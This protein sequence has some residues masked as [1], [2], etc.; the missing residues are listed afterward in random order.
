MS[1]IEHNRVQMGIHI[2]CIQIGIIFR[3][4]VQASIVSRYANS[5]SVTA[6]CCDMIDSVNKDNEGVIIVVFG[7]IDTIRVVSGSGDCG[8][9]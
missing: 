5:R 9:V 8:I 1:A 6:G 7:E 3:I 4:D 2:E